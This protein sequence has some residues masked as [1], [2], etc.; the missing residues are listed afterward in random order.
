MWKN[1]N[2][3]T[4]LY[5]ACGIVPLLCNVRAAFNTRLQ[6]HEHRLLR[7]LSYQC[8]VIIRTH[9]VAN[10]KKEKDKRKKKN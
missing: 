2:S 10:V 3:K 4:G 6:Y 8:L 1:G 5:S 7:S 9:K